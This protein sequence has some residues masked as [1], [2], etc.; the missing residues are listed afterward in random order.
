MNTYVF[1]THDN[2]AQFAFNTDASVVAI[3]SGYATGSITN[4]TDALA[5][6]GSLPNDIFGTKGSLEIIFS[7]SKQFPRLL[8]LGSS[9]AHY[10]DVYVG[11][12][13][14]W[15]GV[16]SN[17][18]HGFSG[19]KLNYLTLRDTSDIVIK[20][21]PLLGDT[22]WKKF[23]GPQCKQTINSTIREE[24]RLTDWVK[25]TPVRKATHYEITVTTSQFGKF[26]GRVGVAFSTDGTWGGYDGIYAKVFKIETPIPL[27]Y[28]LYAACP[29]ELPVDIDGD[30]WVM[31]VLDC[32]KSTDDCTEYRNADNYG[33]AL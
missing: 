31:L 17:A 6:V 27:D 18:T 5:D 9:D 8:A 29:D 24:I 19:V 26:R 28:K 3:P 33:G 16:L 14:N 1:R 7:L 21:R 30:I 22:C 13:L 10:I 25:V 32:N 2:I 20:E 11:G 23:L 12:V 4:T 15:Q